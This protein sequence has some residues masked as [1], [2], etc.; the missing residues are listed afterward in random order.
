MCVVDYL[1]YIE[2]ISLFWDSEKYSNFLIVLNVSLS[3]RPTTYNNQSI[4]YIYPYVLMSL[5]K[6]NL[7]QKPNILLHSGDQ[8]FFLHLTNAVLL[9]DK[10]IMQV[11]IPGDLFI[12]DSCK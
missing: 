4:L 9:M 3:V 6:S 1:N 11:L 5:R 10:I 12:G 8:Y 2:N 7:Y